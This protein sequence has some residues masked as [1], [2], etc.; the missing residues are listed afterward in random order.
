MSLETQFVQLI[1]EHERVIFKITS[2]YA[3]TQA[4][5]HDLYQEIVYQLWKAYANF[6]KESKVSTWLYRV[7]MNT[8]ITRLKKEKRQVEQ[9][10]ISAAVLNRTANPDRDFEERLT[11]LY[12]HIERLNDLEKGLILLFLE[13]KSYE[14][15]AEITG[16]TVSNVGT[17]LSRI[18]QKL[19]SQVKENQLD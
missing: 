10:P 14:E 18:K 11:Q 2:I 8:A 15:M 1:R 13:D 19:K 5:Q 9:V 7:A 16:L 6:R 3:R 12:Q 17:K 4:D